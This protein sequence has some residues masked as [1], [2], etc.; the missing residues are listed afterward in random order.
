MNK[1]WP[2]EKCFQITSNEWSFQV[3]LADS[4]SPN[5]LDPDAQYPLKVWG[6]GAPD[7]V[8][9]VIYFDLSSPPPP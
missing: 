2:D 1:W 8:N 5:V 9:D 6:S 4:T 3:L 7:E